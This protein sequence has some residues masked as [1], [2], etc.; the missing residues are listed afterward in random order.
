MAD[1][2]DLEEGLRW[3]GDPADTVAP[4]VAK[5]PV[6]TEVDEPAEQLSSVLLI[7]Y[8]VIA[9]IYLLYTVGWIFAAV[10]TSSP[11]ADVLVQI[12]FQLGQFFAIAGAPFWFSTVFVLTRSRKPAV[13]LLWLVIGLLV[14]LPLPFI[15]G[16]GA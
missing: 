10:R 11:S 8:G 14:F 15:L 1:D 2:D 16:G 3:D 6:A 7:T 12:M 4:R 5:A 9:G 13:R